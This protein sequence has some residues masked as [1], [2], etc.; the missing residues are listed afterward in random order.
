MGKF[1]DVEFGIHSI[2]SSI[3]WKSKSIKTYPSNFDEIIGQEF[4]RLTI[5]PANPGINFQSISGILNVEIFS[6]SG[7]GPKRFYELSD[8][9]DASLVGKSIN[10]PNGVV[11]F[12]RG[13]ALTLKG[14]DKDNPTL[15]MALYFLPFD[16]Y[17][18]EV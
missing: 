16:F 1:T 7:K 14:R 17:F 2:F 9:L 3:D 13:S 6:E 10:T 8:T 12:N 18:P 11:Q 15:F 5:I 4:L